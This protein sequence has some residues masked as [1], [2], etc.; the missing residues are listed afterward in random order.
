MRVDLINTYSSDNLGDAAIYA[1]LGMLLGDAELNW[2]RPLGGRTGGG[3]AARR[4]SP[5]DVRVSVGGD[6][7]N[8]ARPRLITRAFAANLATLRAGPPERTI[9][10]G[11]SVPRSCHSL[12]F[13]LLARQLRRLASV[14]VRDV[15]SHARLREA[16][17]DA[18]LSWDTAF[19]LEPS[20][21]GRGAAEVLFG[22]QGLDPGRVALMSVRSFNGM[23]RH[24]A[25]AFL[26]RMIR[27]CDLLEARGHQPAILIQ[28]RADAS[29][30][31]LEVAAAVQRARPGVCLLDPFSVSGIIPWQVAAGALGL[32]RIV[33]AVRYHTAV[34]R[35]LSGRGS[36]SLYYSNKG[37]DLVTRA[38]MA[39]CDLAAFDAARELQAIE[40]SASHD[41]D[42]DRIR[43]QVREDFA[44]AISRTAGGEGETRCA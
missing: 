43:R 30:S 27:L 1:A 37:E 8:N 11:Q 26:T 20:A 16:G 3:D 35:A 24:D 15:E 41:V 4:E 21:E 25:G 29:D 12:S 22:A 38:G 39:G 14:C 32:A 2:D 7:F 36:Y 10:F 40:A 42:I 33:V 44:A 31:D 19:A 6:I 28:S 34:L 5:A 13:Q 9:L 23:Y 18:S 17:V